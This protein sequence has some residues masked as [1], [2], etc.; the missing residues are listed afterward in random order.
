[1]R[2]RLELRRVEALEVDAALDLALAGPAAGAG[3]LAGGDGARAGERVA[4]DGEV[5]PLVQ[6][7]VR[8]VVLLH[9]L[10]DVA[11]APVEQRGD[12]V[13]VVARVPLDELGG[14]ARVGLPAADAA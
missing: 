9:V 11:G 4:A 13:A 8:Q 14:F 5:A 10:V 3:V 1:M 12:G 2:G 7:V 6:R